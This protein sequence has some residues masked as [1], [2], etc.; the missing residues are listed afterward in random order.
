VAWDGDNPDIYGASEVVLSIR[1]GTLETDVP[2]DSDLLR[3][4]HLVNRPVNREVTFSL[5][6]HNGENTSF[7]E[8]VRA[9]AQ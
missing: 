1:D 5:R 4:G 7:T 6:V 8:T 9:S 2:L 3:L